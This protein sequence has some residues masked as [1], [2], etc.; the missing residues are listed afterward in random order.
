[1]ELLLDIVRTEGFRGMYRGLS[2]T[3]IALLPNWVP[4]T[5]TSTCICFWRWCF[6]NGLDLMVVPEV[7]IWGGK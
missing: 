1:M 2:P 3:I 6:T 4:G 7:L 5:R